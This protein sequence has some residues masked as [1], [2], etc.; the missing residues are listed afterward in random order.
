MW[1]PKANIKCLLLFLPCFLRQ[2]LS[3]NLEPESSWDS[4]VSASLVFRLQVHVNKPSV[5]AVIGCQHDYICYKL[6]SRN[7][8]ITIKDFF[9]LGLK[10]VNPIIVQNFEAE[11]YISLIGIPIWEDTP[12]IGAITSAR[13]L[14]KETEQA[15]FCSLPD[16][17]PSLSK[18]IP[19]LALGLLWDSNIYWK[20]TKT[21]RNVFYKFCYSGE[22]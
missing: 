21:G 6:Q 12:L 11:G 20:P 18:A 1:K 17:L 3:L 13:R 4:P 9:W 7:R 19:S 5:M 8:S 15:S 16:C 14:Y 22:L 10:W 2:C